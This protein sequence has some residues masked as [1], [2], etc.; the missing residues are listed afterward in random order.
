MRSSHLGDLRRSRLAL[1]AA[2]GLLILTGLDATPAQAA[3]EPATTVVF[4]VDQ[5]PKVQRP[6][7]ERL[8]RQ[9]R[10]KGITLEQ[11]IQSYA[12]QKQ[13]TDLAATANRPD[14]PVTYPNVK[15]DDLT[16]VE[17]MTSL[18]GQA[19]SEGI[20]LSEAIDRDGAWPS[21]KKAILQL[22][23]TY[24]TEWSGVERSDD[25][26]SVWIGFKSAIPAEVATKVRSLPMQVE[27]QG[28][29]GYSEIELR[30]A[31]ERVHRSLRSDPSLKDIASFY[32]ARTGTV[33]SL[34]VPSDTARTSL[35]ADVL[36][37]IATSAVAN[38]AIKVNIEQAAGPMATPYDNYIRGG[39]TL[40]SCTS[41][42]NL[43]RLSDYNNR[44]HGTAGHCASTEV[45]TYCNQSGDGG[46]C[47]TTR[48]YS[49]YQS[50]YGDLAAYAPST[51][52]LTRTFYCAG[53]CKA[54][55][56]D[57]DPGPVVGD[58]VCKFGSLTGRTCGKVRR[59]GYA[60]GVYSDMT[61]TDIPATSNSCWH[62]D[63]GS[64]FWFGDANAYGILYGRG[65]INSTTTGCALT[66]VENLPLALNFHVWTLANSQ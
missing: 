16:V 63:S 49:F 48:L 23:R 6:T 30:Q 20:S 51:L 35:K 36:R 9:A 52:T 32:D 29:L 18:K 7:L 17:I 4:T 19:E 14:G 64:P 12:D 47:D 3:P 21:S 26:R 43:V 45:R 25:G 60:T 53:G 27:L 34:V 39:G 11:A 5:Q 65:Y 41:G 56:E 46:N 31:K 33:H 22:R 57:E 15:I 58:S 54:Y 24:A 44:R 13:K 62:G 50:T 55:V 40:G 2:A 59:L 61:V 38:P 66:H 1:T 37:A 42:F 10:A 28:Q 8:K